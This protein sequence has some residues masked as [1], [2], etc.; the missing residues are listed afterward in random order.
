M[1]TD[2][3]ADDAAGSLR[4][5]VGPLVAAL[6]KAVFGVCA[7]VTG[8]LALVIAVGTDTAGSTTTFVLLGVVALLVGLVTIR[9]LP[10]PDSETAAGDRPADGSNNRR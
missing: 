7:V 1:A 5:A 4:R 9:R 10:K 6:S 3:R 8:V 2:S